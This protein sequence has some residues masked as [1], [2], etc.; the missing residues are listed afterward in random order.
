MLKFRQIPC[1][2]EA[3]MLSI[4]TLLFCVLLRKVANETMPI[5]RYRSTLHNQLKNQWNC[6]IINLRGLR[7][8]NYSFSST[9]VWSFA[10]SIMYPPCLNT[11]TVSISVQVTL[12][13]S[14][15][16]RWLFF[17]FLRKMSS[18]RKKKKRPLLFWN[19]ILLAQSNEN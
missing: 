1:S 15:L 14:V 4:F 19:V 9:Q 7:T 3:K 10:H 11:E 2:T 6:L 18:F 17:F 16:Y 5:L 12:F 13:G 8:V